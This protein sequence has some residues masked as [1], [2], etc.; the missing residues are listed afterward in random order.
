M[1]TI[2]SIPAQP[3]SAQPGQV[4]VG[5]QR[6][7]R[8]T[9]RWVGVV[10]GYAALCLLVALFLVPFLWS[11]SASLKND[12]EIF[13]FPPTFLPSQ[14]LW[15]NYPEA[16]A[17]MRFGLLLRNTLVIAV[18]STLGTLLSSAFVAYGF[19]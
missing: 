1:N 10:A 13:I 7:R 17:Y 15:N 3:S 5:S 8:A 18:L 6:K 19:S 2:S 16:L 9:L 4:Q 11:I 14:P 12:T